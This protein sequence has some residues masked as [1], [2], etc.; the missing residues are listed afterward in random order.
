MEQLTNILN[1]AHDFIHRA[2]IVQTFHIIAQMKDWICISIPFQYDGMKMLTGSVRE[3]NLHSRYIQYV[4]ARVGTEQVLSK[5]LKVKNGMKNSSLWECICNLIR[6]WLNGP[7][8]H[9]RFNGCYGG[10]KEVVDH[11]IFLLGCS[12]NNFLQKYCNFYVL[13]VL[14]KFLWL[15]VPTCGFTNILKRILRLKKVVWWVLIISTEKMHQAK[16]VTPNYNQV[17]AL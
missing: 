4:R 1:N 13:L 5:I 3:R 2:I 11:W 10:L 15:T 7:N 9:G 12:C 8:W 14:F 6:E 16:P 17:T